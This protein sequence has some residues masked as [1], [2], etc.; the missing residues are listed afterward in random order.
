MEN[1]D[2]WTLAW[3]FDNIT[4][5][6]YGWISASV[7]TSFFIHIATSLV[8]FLSWFWWL[9]GDGR[10]FGWWTEH[11]G[12]WGSVIAFPV[13]VLFAILQLALDTEMG[14]FEGNY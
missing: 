14:G 5:T 7:M 8:E 13:P 2:S 11:I 10:L 6:Q 1:A 9:A 12:W 3:A 4:S